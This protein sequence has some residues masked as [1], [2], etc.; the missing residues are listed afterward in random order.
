[1]IGLNDNASTVSSVPTIR[2]TPRYVDF[3]S[4]TAAAVSAIARL[5][6][7]NHSIRKHD[8]TSILQK[9]RSSLTVEI[10][11]IL[12]SSVLDFCANSLES[13]LDAGCLPGWELGQATGL[14]AEFFIDRHD[15]PR[16]DHQILRKDAL[17]PG[18]S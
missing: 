14:L 16:F 10:V 12:D 3:S 8:P 11:T 18:F 6:I 4:K 9:H 7:Q 2:A 5:T 17:W 13:G 15:S 1:M